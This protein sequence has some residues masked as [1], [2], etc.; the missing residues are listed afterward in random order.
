M[1]VF[2]SG[3]LIITGSVTTSGTITAQTL[4]V[5]TITSSIV[6]MTGS[7]IFGSVLTDRQTFTGS[8][9][10][11]GSL[12][13]N[14]TGTEFQV[15]NNGVV[16]GNLLT[17]NHSITGSLRI[18]GSSVT[19]A[20]PL[21]GSSATFTGTL[22]ATDG[23]QGLNVRAYTGGAGF[24]AIY[25]TGVTAGA[26][27][28]ALAASSTQTILSGVDSVNLAI[29]SAIKL[30]ISSS[31]NVG[32]GTT[33]PNALLQCNG[34]AI[35]GSG[36]V[37][38]GTTFGGG[39]QI[40]RL[41]V[42][43]GNYTC[44]EVN[45]STS[46]GSIQFT[47]G[48]NLP[49]QVSALIGYNYASGTVN[50]LAISNILSGPMIL[51][52]N[53][54]ERMRITSAGNVGFNT[55]SPTGSRATNLVQVAGSLAVLRVGPWFSTDD[56]DFVEIQAD[57]ANTRL[58]SPNEDFS[59]HNPIGNAN[60]TGSTVNICAASNIYVRN[61]GGGSTTLGVY[62]ANATSANAGLYLEAPGVVG[63]GMYQDRGTSTLRVWQATSTVG[64][65]L[66]NNATSW[67]SFSDERMK[68]I[69]EPI[70]NAVDKVNTLRTVIGKYKTDEED[71]R[72]PFLIAQDVQA[73]LP[74]A[75]YDDKSE[76]K[77][78]SLS[79]TDVIPLLVASIKE[80]TAKVTALENK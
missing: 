57:G 40:N 76:D 2:L 38:N 65:S 26:G 13:V 45:G 74:E 21:T 10:M 30:A 22:T 18:T 55:T 29:N 3:S 80:L 44:L 77:F 58:Y 66:A 52:T 56:R 64:V 59:F 23:T 32:I 15:T 14:T 70:T 50:E 6:N 9:V 39:G 5:Q 48:S 31:G 20:G 47:Y 41:K 17:D 37:S 73:I 24:G 72:R 4:V 36:T 78:L 16:M 8:V 67:G 60:I 25:S 79:Y 27:N 54:T 75:V 11:T 33:S 71:K 7:N 43:S 53:N 28:F 62:A 49:N 19:L 12:T 51:A 34:S 35:I 69:I 42:E 61:T 63:G 68:D 46:G 1:P